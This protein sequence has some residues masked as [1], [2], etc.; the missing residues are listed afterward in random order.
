MCSHNL[1]MRE[2][3]GRIQE[4]EVK[5]LQIERQDN[6]M[7][8]TEIHSSVVRENSAQE[9]YSQ[10]MLQRLQDENARLRLA[11]SKLFSAKT[12]LE[13][14]QAI[15]DNM[16]KKLKDANEALRAEV[17]E[18]RCQDQER[19]QAFQSVTS[20]CIRLEREIGLLDHIS[21][22]SLEVLHV[23]Y[24][25]PGV[26]MENILR[27][28][29][30]SCG[31][32]DSCPTSSCGKA[33]Q[34]CATS[35][36]KVLNQDQAH[37]IVTSKSLV[38]APCNH[39]ISE[40]QLSSVLYNLLNSSAASEPKN[41]IRDKKIN[42]QMLATHEKLYHYFHLT[43]QSIIHEG[44]SHDKLFPSSSRFAIDQ[45]YR[46]VVT[47]DISFLL[48][49]PWLSKRIAHLRAAFQDS[50]VSKCQVKSKS[51]GFL[52]RLHWRSNPQTLDDSSSIIHNRRQVSRPS[53]HP[54]LVSKAIQ[55]QSQSA[56]L[57][58]FQKRLPQKKRRSSTNRSQP[59]NKAGL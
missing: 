37:A 5:L 19:M 42:S 40:G 45:W 15:H 39:R 51:F 46:E 6:S 21:N 30:S 43:A 38:E 18:L 13:M 8:Q 20:K 23:D 53:C 3:R 58:F 33:G 24:R 44:S 31:A 10:M 34:T 49:H 14:S 28:K 9:Q 36:V 41:T 35:H 55:A 26:T 57:L 2:A 22:M 12:T 4:L 16:C 7:P 48:W 1:L 50:T 47:K 27:E 17:D 59:K 52:R 29:R 11:N 32:E 56:A 54:A 25:E